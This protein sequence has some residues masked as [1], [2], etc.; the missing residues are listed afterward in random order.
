MWVDL[1]E[2]GPSD[3]FKDIGKEQSRLPE[4]LEDSVSAWIDLVPGW[5]QSQSLMISR[6]EYGLSNKFLLL[7]TGLTIA[8]GWLCCEPN[9]D[10]SEVKPY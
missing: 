8:F 10:L 9:S 1:Q 6:A 4:I 3:K 7:A 5:I 2:G